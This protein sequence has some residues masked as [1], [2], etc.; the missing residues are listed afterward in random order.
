VV[1]LGVVFCALRGKVEGAWEG[2]RPNGPVPRWFGKDGFIKF[3]LFAKEKCQAVGRK[4]G[5]W[6]KRTKEVAGKK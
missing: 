1:Q 3:R 4:N 2:A 5:E 6:G